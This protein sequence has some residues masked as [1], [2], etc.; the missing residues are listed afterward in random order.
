MQSFINNFQL[1][2]QVDYEDELDLMWISATYQSPKLRGVVC[3]HDNDTGELIREVEIQER[4][5]E[6]TIS[7]HVTQ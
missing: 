4:W 5:E 3:F 2:H 6:V 1:I 7:Y